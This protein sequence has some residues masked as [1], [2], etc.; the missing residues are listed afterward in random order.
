MR[1][2]NTGQRIVIVVGLGVALY[3]FGGWITTRGTGPQYGWV[4]YAPLSNAYNTPNLLGSLRPWVRLVIW[5][6]L[7]LVWAV[8]SALLLRLPARSEGDGPGE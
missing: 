2:M 4:A 7:I 6:A 1:R 5:L 3:F 8:A